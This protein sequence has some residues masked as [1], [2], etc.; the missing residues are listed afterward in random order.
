MKLLT[1]LCEKGERFGP[2]RKSYSQS[3]DNLCQLPVSTYAPRT[4][5]CPLET[6]KNTKNED[7]GQKP[8]TSTVM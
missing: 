6:A 3:L 4:K 7:K 2:K 8:T 1:C 5:F